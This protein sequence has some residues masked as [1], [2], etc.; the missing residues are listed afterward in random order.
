MALSAVVS[1][2]NREAGQFGPKTIIRGTM[3][4][5][6][7]Y[8]TNGEAFLKSQIGL[9]TID[10]LII[11]PSAGY[12]FEYDSAAVKVKVYWGDN[13]NAADAPAVEVANTTDLSAL[14]LVPFEA[15]GDE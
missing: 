15:V 14:T 7:S 12:T 8:P 6:A 9:A 13:N 1:S 4:F 2:K 10:R 11:F 5:D 3:A